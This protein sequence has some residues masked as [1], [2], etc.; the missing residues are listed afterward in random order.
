MHKNPLITVY[1]T[2]HNYG[3][4]IEKSINSVLAQTFQDFEIIIIDDGSTD[5]SKKKIEK[6]VKNKK[7]KLSIKKIKALLSPIILQLKHHVENILL[8]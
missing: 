5:N 3:K 2:N 8:G 6:F 7:I 1:I 4:Y